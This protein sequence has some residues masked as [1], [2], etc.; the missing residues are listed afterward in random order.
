[1]AQPETAL[2]IAR[3]HTFDV[4]LVDI[5]LPEIDGYEVSR[6][7]RELDGGEHLH[8]VA[9]TGFGRPEDVVRAEESGFDDHLVKP[10]DMQQLRGLLAVKRRDRSGGKGVAAGEAR[11][12]GGAGLSG[13]VAPP[14]GST[15]VR[16]CS[17]RPPGGSVEPRSVRP[18]PDPLAPFLRG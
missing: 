18:P 2:E 17:T 8:L 14:A 9:L 1:M 12:S 11:A 7:L 6:R 16:G 15:V 5:G 4:A 3:E 10:V 13:S